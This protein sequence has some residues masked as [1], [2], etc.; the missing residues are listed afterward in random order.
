MKVEWWGRRR[1]GGEEE[2]MRGW[3][4]TEEVGKK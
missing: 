1:E 2:G 3:G 4:K